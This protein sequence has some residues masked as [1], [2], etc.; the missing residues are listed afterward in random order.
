MK[1]LINSLLIT[2]SWVCFSPEGLT[3]S[4]LMSD[5]LQHSDSLGFI[6]LGVPEADSKMRLLEDLIIN[7]QRER[8][9]KKAVILSAV[10][11][12]A[13]QVYNGDYLKPGV[14]YGIVG[15]LLY[16]LDFNKR[17]FDR[18][19][20]A[21]EQRLAGEQDEFVGLIP[22]AQGIRSFRDRYRKD[23]ELTY[24]GL[25]ITYLFNVMD[26]FVSAHL[27]T[28]DIDE[29]LSIHLTPSNS[30]SVVGNSVG[31]GLVLNF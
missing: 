21:Y 11:P 10:I 13:G 26:V 18:F 7:K 30:T 14:I 29:D 24:I 9:P 5:S 20:L 25:G 28:F 19:N 15:S 23:M 2:L 3:L 22:S 31:I 17:N 1:I 4:H 6:E 16:A 27:T 12:G 8:D